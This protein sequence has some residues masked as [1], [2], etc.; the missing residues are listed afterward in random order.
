MAGSRDITNSPHA[1]F[2]DFKA[3]YD[4]VDRDIL[5]RRL[6]ALHLLTTE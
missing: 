4:S 1:L 5:Y 2:F 6:E 3:A